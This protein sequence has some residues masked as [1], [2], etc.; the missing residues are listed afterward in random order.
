MFSVFNHEEPYTRPKCSAAS[1]VRATTLLDRVAAVAAQAR[2]AVRDN[3]LRLWRS[4]FLKVISIVLGFGGDSSI[5]PASP[6]S[7]VFGHCYLRRR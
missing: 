4:V 3:P 5:R 7:D 6:T 2:P 1:S